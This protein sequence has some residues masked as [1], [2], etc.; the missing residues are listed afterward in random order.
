MPV[1][2]GKK[3]AKP[4]K[5]AAPPA[6]GGEPLAPQAAGL[7]MNW[8]GKSIRRKEEARLIRG[9]GKFVDD[10]KCPEALYLCFVRS[11]YGHARITKIDVSE[12]EQA[13]GVVCTLTGAEIAKQ[14]QPFLEIGPEPGAKIVDYPMAVAK[15]RYQ[16]EPV[17]AV[18]AESQLAAVDAAELVRVDYEPLP[19][20]VDT[21]EALKDQIILHESAGTN[22][23]YRGTFDY[24]EV[25][26]AFR[27]AAHVVR[28]ERLHFHRFSSTPLENN[29]IIA[30][31]DAGDN[32]IN[33]WGNNSF[34]VIGMQLLSMAMGVRME[35][36]RFQ[37]HDIGGSFGIKINN[38]VYMALCALACMCSVRVSTHF[39]GRPPAL[40]EASA[41][42]AM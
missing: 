32:R 25:D 29:A 17:V 9:Q 35:Q 6:A 21:E 26:E 2:K 5:A 22:V 23:V 1:K 16:G 41:Q 13:P 36:M 39:T 30:Q 12:A 20:V 42:S 15:A 34:P 7:A 11:P 37:S 31:W 8:I 33:F 3:A 18:V 28:I 40:R 14:M 38:Y 10:I 19:A 4:K 24:G 27:E